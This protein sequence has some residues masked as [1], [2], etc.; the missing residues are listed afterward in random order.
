MCRS[1]PFAVLVLA[2]LAS[3]CSI[4]VST[5]PGYATQWEQRNDPPRASK[6]APR[7]E[8]RRSAGAG[9]AS[10]GAAAHA[11]NSAPTPGSDSGGGGRPVFPRVIPSGDRGV[12]GFVTSSHIGGSAPQTSRTVDRTQARSPRLVNGRSPREGSLQGPRPVQAASN[13]SNQED[14]RQQGLPTD[15]RWLHQLRGRSS[16]SD[17]QPAGPSSEDND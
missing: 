4:H 9:H 8:S 17:A 1:K 6:I 3:A 16:Q 5:G 15:D 13:A 14:L 7:R 10:S 11:Q 12:A 2:S